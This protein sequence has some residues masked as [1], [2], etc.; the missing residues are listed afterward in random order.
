MCLRDQQRYSVAAVSRKSLS[1]F[2]FHYKLSLPCDCSTCD[3]RIWVLPVD[4][5]RAV[6]AAIP[7]VHDKIFLGLK[8]TVRRSTR[9][10]LAQLCDHLNKKCMRQHPCSTLS[11]TIE[12]SVGSQPALMGRV[13][14]CTLRWLLPCSPGH[15]LQPKWCC[16]TRSAGPPQAVQL[17]LLR[18]AHLKLPQDVSSVMNLPK[19]LG[20][21][22]IY[23]KLYNLSLPRLSLVKVF[24]KVM[25]GQD[26]ERQLAK[27]E[28]MLPGLHNAVDM[29]LVQ[30]LSWY[31]RCAYEAKQATATA[32][33]EATMSVGNAATD[34]GTHTHGETLTTLPSGPRGAALRTAVHAIGTLA[35]RKISAFVPHGRSIAGS[36]A[37]NSFLGTSEWGGS[38]APWPGATAR[39]GRYAGPSVKAAGTPAARWRATLRRVRAAQRAG[40]TGAWRD[41]PLGTTASRGLS[42]SPGASSRI[43]SAHGAGAPLSSG[44]G[45][46]AGGGRGSEDD[47]LSQ[48]AEELHLVEAEREEAARARAEA[49]HSASLSKVGHGDCPLQL[50]VSAHAFC[51]APAHW[52]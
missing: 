16:I 13:T 29:G 43:A 31:D 2:C 14:G 52:P 10:N 22:Q 32:A 19:H 23:N 45:G 6:E 1:R 12:R 41:A 21:L 7:S 49:E 28:R 44:A 30:I 17:S 39:G 4:E 36:R 40:L 24:L 8:R 48:F 51:A 33:Q 20:T 3:C 11:T 50:R 35:R 9:A 5:L 42:L 37:D 46:A 15:R 47:E 18:S 34:G 26:S 38:D 27:I 25:S